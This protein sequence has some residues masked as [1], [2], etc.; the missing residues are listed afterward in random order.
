M[1]VYPGMEI[2]ICDD[3]HAQLEHQSLISL[4]NTRYVL[5]ELPAQLI[6]PQF[7]DVVFN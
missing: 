1:T 2:H 4:N 3:L 5:I 6:P 7:K